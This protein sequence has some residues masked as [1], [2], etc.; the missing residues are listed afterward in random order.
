MTQKVIRS[1]E[2]QAANCIYQRR[3]A[4]CEKKMKLCP[5][6][7]RLGSWW[8]LDLISCFHLAVGMKSKTRNTDI[9]L[10]L[11]SF[12]WTQACNIKLQKRQNKEGWNLFIN[13]YPCYVLFYMFKCSLGEQKR[14]ISKSLLTPNF[15]KV[16][17]HLNH[18]YFLCRACCHNL[19]GKLS[20]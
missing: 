11:H 9:G 18:L 12:T 14:V 1:M 17:L 3:D 20:Q 4:G 19:W 2:Q 15:W 6:K 7:L 5:R 8:V 16:V 10:F 13:I